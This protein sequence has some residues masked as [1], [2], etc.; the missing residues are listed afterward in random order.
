MNALFIFL[1]VLTA[2]IIYNEFPIGTIEFF[3]SGDSCQFNILKVHDADGGGFLIKKFKDKQQVG[4]PDKVEDKDQLHEYFKKHFKCV[5]NYFNESSLESLPVVDPTEG[6]NHIDY[7]KVKQTKDGKF[8][9]ETKKGKTVEK[10]QPEIIEMCIIQLRYELMQMPQCR[11][12][13]INETK[14]YTTKQL[15]T[16]CPLKNPKIIKEGDLYK[17]IYDGHER[18]PYN[19]PEKLERARE[20]VSNLTK[21]LNCR[22]IINMTDADIPGTLRQDRDPRVD[23][24]IRKRQELVTAP[25]TQGQS[26]TRDSTRTSTD[27]LS[28]TPLKQPKSESVAITSDNVTGADTLRPLNI[29]NASTEEILSQSSERRLNNSVNRVSNSAAANNER[30]AELSMKLEREREL[31]QKEHKQAVKLSLKLQ[32]YAD[33]TNKLDQKTR[34]QQAILQNRIDK[35]KQDLADAQKLTHDFPDN[36]DAIDMRIKVENNKT[37]LVSHG[38]RLNQIEELLYDTK[39]CVENSKTLLEDISSKLSNNGMLCKKDSLKNLVTADTIRNNVSKC[40]ACPVYSSTYPVDVLEVE[41]QKVG[42]IAPKPT[43]LNSE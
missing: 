23:E 32:K 18:N 8:Y 37:R 4:T 5:K 34:E 7:I 17:L 33:K 19:K 40:P 6:C 12:K 1:L 3:E 35:L 28:V 42:T 14:D 22:R 24:L 16:S 43:Y 39:A 26:S 20:D 21:M 29:N 31:S 36:Q 30:L 2:I 27:S 41:R 38:K 15:L 25:R 9:L 10:T 11:S 13:V